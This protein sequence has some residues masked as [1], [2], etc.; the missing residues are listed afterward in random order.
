MAN[1]RRDIE[2]KCIKIRKLYEEGHYNEALEIVDEFDGE[3]PESIRDLRVIA[4][5]QEKT[6][7]IDD[8]KVTYAQ[9]C[10]LTRTHHALRDFIRALIRV[11]DYVDAGLYLDKYEE[12]EGA[13][14]DDFEMRY[15]LMKAFGASLD[16]RIDLLEKFKK[17]EYM[18]Q[19]GKELAE[20]YRDAGRDED[21]KR[22]LADL[23]LWFGG[24]R[25]IAEE[26]IKPR[27][28]DEEVGG[29]I[30]ENL[31]AKLEEENSIEE[32]ISE[33]VAKEVSR[34]ADSEVLEA[35]KEPLEETLDDILARTA[36][37]KPQMMQEE[38]T[39]QAEALDPDAPMIES[40]GKP[41][42]VSGKPLDEEFRESFEAR[43][44]NNK[45]QAETVGTPVVSEKKTSASTEVEKL[46]AVDED[47][48]EGPEDISARGIRY[49]TTKD[50][51]AKL[52][53]GDF[54][55]PH[56]VLAGGEEKTILT[57]SKKLS[58]ELTRLGYTSAKKVVKISSERLNRLK[59][60]EQMEKLLGAC[61][62]VTEAAE[63]T[64][65]SVENLLDVMHEFGEEF[66]VMLAGPFDEMDCFL[67]IYPELSEQLGYKV[68]MLL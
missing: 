20:C 29:E 30:E 38:D 37:I 65:D 10:E 35:K 58:K 53:R 18:E 12:M 36:K 54:K 33:S 27:K 5:L 28:S 49:W 51:I 26:E 46:F 39:K 11:Q 40:V 63:M 8:M 14:V 52:R 41:R 62:L 61:L 60:T 50:T 44:L 32:E 59:L 24:A 56:F 34:I 43:Y 4:D 7:R 16:E 15:E 48:E 17:Q 31:A 23:N 22:E 64:K 47:Y 25:F 67:E 68:R 21:Y 6:K 45:G 13:T 2:K 66:V 42:T 57:M 19:W 9:L 3:L 55:P 1:K